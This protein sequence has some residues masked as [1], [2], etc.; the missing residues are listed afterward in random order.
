[1]KSRKWRVI[2]CDKDTAASRRGFFLMCVFPYYGV[3]L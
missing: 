1:M 3:L 2:S